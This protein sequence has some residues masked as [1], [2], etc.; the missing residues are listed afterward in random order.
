MHSYKHKESPA[1]NQRM[2]VVQAWHRLPLSLA[3]LIMA[4]PWLILLW[5]MVGS[6]LKMQTRTLQQNEEGRIIRSGQLSAQSLKTLFVSA[7]QVLLELRRYWQ[8]HPT[9]FQQVLQDRFDKLELSEAFDVTVIDTLGHVVKSRKQKNALDHPLYDSTLWSRHRDK[10]QDRLLI[11]P[12]FLDTLTGLWLLPFTRPLLSRSGQ[13]EGL[14]TFLAPTDYLSRV[15]QSTTL[16][17]DSV[18]SIIDLESGNLILRGTKTHDPATEQRTALSSTGF[19]AMLSAGAPMERAGVMVSQL[20]HPISRLSNNGLAALAALPVSGM[21][22]TRFEVDPIERLYFWEKLERTPLLLSVGA[23]THDFDSLVATHQLRHLMTGIAFSLLALAFAAGFNIDVRS[24][25]RSQQALRQLAAHQTDLIEDE[26]KLLAREIHD[27]LG[28]RLTALRLD[29]AMTMRAMQSTCSAELLAQ[30]GQLKRAIDDILRIA[31]ELAQKV[32]PPSLDI[33]FLPAVEA[34]C[35][36]FNERLPATVR[37]THHSHTRIDPSEACGIAAYRLLQESLN[38]AARHAHCQHID[39]SLDVIDGWL[40][41]RVIDDGIGFDAQANNRK[42]TFGLLG[43][44]ERVAA[45]GG[46]MRLQSQPGQGSK[47]LVWLPLNGMN[48][49][50][51]SRIGHQ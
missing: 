7:D 20:P 40:S 15:L 44:R 25:R 46:E 29:L 10:R 1:N 11:G 16:S 5:T 8:H 9:E 21:R 39:I 35:D 43:M 18:F 28:Q 27:D 22:R 31:R 34:L 3:S 38:N 6:N 14:I 30:V 26:R 50:K 4:A 48:A 41:L 36:E 19:W 13:F 51:G 17:H 47:L 42:R 2:R 12:A 49:A 33:G 45:L 37:L 24:R 23:A 32:R